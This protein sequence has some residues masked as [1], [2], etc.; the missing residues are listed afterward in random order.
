M[1]NSRTALFAQLLLVIFI[2][3]SQSCFAQDKKI[4]ATAGNWGSFLLDLDEIASRHAE[5]PPNGEIK[6]PPPFKLPLV[7]DDYKDFEKLLKELRDLLKDWPWK[8]ILERY[9]TDGDGT[10]SPDEIK[11]FLQDR[12][13]CIPLVLP[14]EERDK[15]IDRALCFFLKKADAGCDLSGIEISPAIL[16]EW[17]KGWIESVDF[18]ITFFCTDHPDPVRCDYFKKLKEEIEKT[19]DKFREG[20][21]CPKPVGGCNCGC[22]ADC[23]CRRQVQNSTAHLS[24]M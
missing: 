9:D 7:P 12:V 18:Q 17:F 14:C 3:L 6:P 21:P 1:R 13:P 11:R 10:L 4:D 19:R 24:E 8:K 2:C 23:P 5:Q 22:A 15:I 20:I 16:E